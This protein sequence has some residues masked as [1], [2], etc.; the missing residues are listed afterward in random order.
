MSVRGFLKKTLVTSEIDRQV[1]QFKKVVGSFGYDAWGFNSE[2][3]KVALALI[4]PLYEDYF[5]VKAYGVDNVPAEGPVLIIPNHSG[6][7]PLDGLLAGYAIATRKKEPRAARAMIE[8]FFPT[9]P[10]L[11]NMLNAI[12]AVIGDPLNCARMLDNGEAVIVFPEGIRGSGKMYE[13]RYQLQRFGSGFMHLAINHKTPI[14]PA[15]IIGC[16]ETMP[17]IYNIKPLAKMLGIPYAPVTTPIPLPAR[18]SIHFGEPICFEGADTEEEIV[19]K[20]ELVKDKIR[21]LI[22]EGLSQ[23]E[24]VY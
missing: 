24:S 23:R 20:V 7:L 2:S 17:A 21:E 4:R 15:G 16:E 13:Q 6:Q 14:V 8:R 22:A 10:F 12:G 11:G 3:A 18:V 1:N 5:R 9:V 19:Q